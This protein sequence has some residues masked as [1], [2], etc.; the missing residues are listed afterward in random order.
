MN[1]AEPSTPPPKLPVFME[2]SA[3]RRSEGRRNRQYTVIKK[4]YNVLKVIS[5][6]E[7]I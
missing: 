1:N 4:L 3:G 7:E 2:L 6:V 5:A